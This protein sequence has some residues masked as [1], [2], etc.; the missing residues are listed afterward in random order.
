MR[1]AVTPVLRRRRLP[2]LAGSRCL[3][4]PESSPWSLYSGAGLLRGGE[5]V[6]SS[7]DGDSLRTVDPHRFSRNRYLPLTFPAHRTTSAHADVGKRPGCC[8][9]GR[10]PHH[11]T[12]L[13][14]RRATMVKRANQPVGRLGRRPPPGGRSRQQ[15]LLADGATPRRLLSTVGLLPHHRPL[16]NEHRNKLPHF[17]NVDPGKL[18]LE[19]GPGNRK[20]YGS[21]LQPFFRPFDDSTKDLFVSQAPFAQLSR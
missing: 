15:T 17:L 4:N 2:H 7:D 16:P 3:P 19:W 10:N 8:R 5:G 20:E 18:A 11:D 21:C 6:H 14:P 12:W 13:I 9:T 1:R